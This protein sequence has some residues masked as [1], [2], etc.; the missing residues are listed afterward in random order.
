MANG[1]NNL[2][3]CRPENYLP[4]KIAPIGKKLLTINLFS[5]EMV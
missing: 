1:C 3:G 4:Q 5:G 2:E